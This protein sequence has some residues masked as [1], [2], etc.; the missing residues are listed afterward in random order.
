MGSLIWKEIVHPPNSLY[1]FH[2]TYNLIYLEEKPP[3]SHIPTLALCLVIF[4]FKFCS[5]ERFYLTC[6]KGGIRADFS[7]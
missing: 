4:L 3:G 6:Q 2:Y 5:P 7:A 1:L